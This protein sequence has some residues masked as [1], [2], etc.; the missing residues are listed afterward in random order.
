MARSGD[1][2]DPVNANE[3]FE[4]RVSRVALLNGPRAG[5]IEAWALE[6]SP[7]LSELGAA[8]NRKPPPQAL[9][10]YSSDPNEPLLDPERRAG[11]LADVATAPDDVSFAAFGKQ[12]CQQFRALRNCYEMDGS[13]MDNEWIA[14]RVN[15]DVLAA[16]K[17][18]GGPSFSLFSGDIV[19]NFAPGASG[20]AFTSRRWT[21]L[22]ADPLSD[23]GVPAFGAIG[24]N[25]LMS[26]MACDPVVSGQCV[27]ASDVTAGTRPP[28][29]SGAKRWRRWRRGRKKQTAPTP[30][31]QA[32]LA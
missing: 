28:T 8:A 25:D 4:G 11:P 3:E 14:N 9:L 32:P 12:D 10:H 29:S 7:A 5:Q 18:P 13:N 2:M 15:Q 24:Q 21:E 30:S 23:G 1:T 19:D 6:Q 31:S 20:F 16:A 22:I 17:R 27:G 26:A